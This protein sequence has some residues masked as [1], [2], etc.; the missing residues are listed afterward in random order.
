MTATA[1]MISGTPA[2]SVTLA[3]DQA[4]VDLRVVAEEDGM[5]GVDKPQVEA[6]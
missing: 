2:T 4:S 1:S 5:D 6:G 3:A